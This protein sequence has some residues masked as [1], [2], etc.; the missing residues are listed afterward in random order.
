MIK[1]ANIPA[2]VIEIPF[3]FPVKSIQD[4]SPL[5]ETYHGECE[6]FSKCVCVC[7]YLGCSHAMFLS[8]RFQK[9]C[10]FP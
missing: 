4:S 8:K 7:L 2:G 1:N 3:E 6:L 5:L 9:F 10:L